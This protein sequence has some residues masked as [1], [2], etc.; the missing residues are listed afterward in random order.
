MDTPFD[1]FMPT[2]AGR[3][4]SRLPVRAARRR[5][6]VPPRRHRA[7]LRAGARRGAA[8]ARALRRRRLRP[9]PSRGAAAREPAGVLLPL[10]RAERARARA[11]CRSIPTT[12][13]TRCSTRWTTRRRSS[14]WRSPSARGRPRSGGARARQAAARGR[15]RGA[16]RPR[17][18]RR[19]RRR[20]RARPASTP[21]AR[22]STRRAP[23]AG[24]RAACSTNF[25]YLNAGAWYRDLGGR[26]AIEHG[27]ERFLNPLPLFHM[28][29]HGGDGHVRHPHRQLP[30]PA[31]A[32]QPA[33]LV[34]GRGRDRAP[35]SSTTWA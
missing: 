14:R 32:L 20:A 19:S 7:H 3:A 11:S 30:R 8:L 25:Y 35:P 18:P 34:G 23:P 4:R 31:R 2:A 28:N 12:A 17:C 9:R 10:S 24:P 15:R 6:R 5:P 13:T 29:C 27:R 1:A 22:C 26:L 21:S 16:G 33:P